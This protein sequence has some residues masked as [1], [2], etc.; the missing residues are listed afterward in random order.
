MRKESFSRL[1]SPYQIYFHMSTRLEEFH[2]EIDVMSIGTSRPYRHATNQQH[3]GG[4]EVEST[5]KQ[6]CRFIGHVQL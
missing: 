3:W 2:I 6:Y 5:S 4:V 1:G